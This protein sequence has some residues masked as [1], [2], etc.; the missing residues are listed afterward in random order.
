[1]P[2]DLRNVIGAPVLG[3]SGGN[4]SAVFRLD[5]FDPAPIGKR[6]LGWIDDLHDMALSTTTGQ[7]RDGPPHFGNI[8]PEI[9]EQNHLGER[10]GRETWRQARALV[11]I[12]YDRLSDPLDDVAAACRTHQAGNSNAFAALERPKCPAAELRSRSAG[13]EWR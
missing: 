10:G 3:P 13:M 7:L 4:A 12:D 11:A 2:R 5:E 9:R 6:L 8:A 1:M